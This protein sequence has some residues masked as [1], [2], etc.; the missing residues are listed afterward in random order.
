MKIWLIC[1]DIANNKRRYYVDKTLQGY[2]TRIQQSAFECLVTDTE[3]G[4]LQS[5]L[6]QHINQDDLINYY[7]MCQWCQAKRQGQGQAEHIL[8]QYQG[9]YIS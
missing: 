5:Q 7:P 6:K 2:G 8:K 4:V 9:F 1:Y 3:L